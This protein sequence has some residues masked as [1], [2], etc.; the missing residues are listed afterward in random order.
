MSSTVNNSF[1]TSIPSKLPPLYF[2]NKVPVQ[3]EW[4]IVCD[5]KGNL[6]VGNIQ[7]IFVNDELAAKTIETEFT[8]DGIVFNDS[9]ILTPYVADNTKTWV[10]Y[11]TSANFS[12]GNGA[13]SLDPV[14]ALN[15]S[16]LNPIA[17]N[18]SVPTALMLDANPLK[19]SAFKFRLR[20]TDPVG[21]NPRLKAIAEVTIIK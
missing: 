13:N 9:G 2:V 7:L 8:I 17:T 18:I 1:P 5:V 20:M 19:C 3:N 15:I 21:T 14:R 10:L 6:Q 11:M 16:A 4:Y 12:D